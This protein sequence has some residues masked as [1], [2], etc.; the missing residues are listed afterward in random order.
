MKNNMENNKKQQTAFSI[1]DVVQQVEKAI[2]DVFVEKEIDLDDAIKILGLAA[3]ELIDTCP[4]EK[5]LLENI[6]VFNKCFAL[7]II[8]DRIDEILALWNDE[9]NSEDKKENSRK[10]NKRKKNRK[11][12]KDVPVE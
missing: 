12:N 4:N 8:L 11:N 1:L 5:K 6:D 7:A 9:D 10:K 3:G 2:L